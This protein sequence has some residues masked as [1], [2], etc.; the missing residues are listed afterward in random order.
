MAAPATADASDSALLNRTIFFV[1]ERTGFLKLVDTYDIFDPA[2]NR[3]IGIAKEEPPTWAK[4]LRLAVEKGKLPTVVNVY[5]AEGA[6]PVLSIHRGFT[7]LR[8]KMHVTCAGR[9]LGYFRSK[10]ISIGGGFHVFN[11]KDEQV[12]EVKGNWKGWDFKF[13]TKQGREIGTVTK[14]WA[15]LGKELFTSADN[16]VISLNGLGGANPEAAALLLAAGLAIDIVF[17]EAN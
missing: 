7:F 14:K 8:S 2:T 16:Y 6:P 11:T 5:E 13:L 4:F 12:A 10:L 3:Q 15:G 17:K 9:K 1:K